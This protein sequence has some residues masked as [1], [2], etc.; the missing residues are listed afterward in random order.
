VIALAICAGVSIG[1]VGGVLFSTWLT[2]QGYGLITD[3]VDK[4][5]TAA[6]FPGLKGIVNEPQVPTGQQEMF[7]TVDRDED[8]GPARVPAWL[9]DE[10]SPAAWDPYQEPADA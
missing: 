10:R 5:T 9:S 6:L 7:G 4:I 8:E 1:F 3:T 2:K